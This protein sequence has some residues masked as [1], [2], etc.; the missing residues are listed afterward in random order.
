MRLSKKDK[1]FLLSLLPLATSVLALLILIIFAILLRSLQAINKFGLELLVSSVWSPE[2]EIYGVLAPLIGSLATS[3][4]ATLTALILS[5]PL[6]IAASEYLKGFI[7]NVF[8]SLIELA[9]GMPTIIYA[10][11]ASEYLVP[12]LKTYV[13]EPLHRL[14]PFIPLFSC[15]PITGFSIFAAGVAIGISV[16]PY[17]TALILESYNSI[18]AMYKEACYGIGAYRHEAVS[19]LLSL[20]R[21]AIVASL[22]L[23][24]A[25]ALGETTIAV[26]T[27][28]SS[29]YLSSCLFAP[30]YTVAA[31]I[32]TQFANANLYMY[33]ESVL[34]TAALIVTVIATILSFYGSVIMVRWRSRIVV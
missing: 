29:M 34:Y 13:M 19:I 6:A 17:V 33:A 20:S 21:P 16:V 23:G 27:V 15:K 2:Q 30:G 12:F 26:T 1:L 11:W 18:P 24:F 7:K 14:L 5:I 31:L 28:G 10:V 8:S 9:G 32:A 3:V 4:I 25:R 22:L